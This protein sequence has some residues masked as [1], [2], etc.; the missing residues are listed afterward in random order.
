MICSFVE[1]G[2]LNHDLDGN[3]KHYFRSQCAIRVY[4]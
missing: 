4:W 2:T 1:N 3:I